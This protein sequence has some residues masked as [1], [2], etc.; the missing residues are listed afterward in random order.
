[1]SKPRQESPSFW[2][3]FGQPKTDASPPSPLWELFASEEPPPQAPVPCALGFDPG[4][5]FWAMRN[6]PITE[7]TKHFVICG[8]TG[9]G[10]TVGIQLFLQSI[11]PRFRPEAKVPEQLILFDAKCD[12]VPLL[13]ALGLGPGNSNVWILNPY[14][15]RSAVWNLGEATDTP[16]MARALAAL[17]VPDERN[18]NAPYFSDAARELVYAVLLALNRIAKTEWTLRDLLCALESREHIQEV[19]AQDPRAQ[20]LVERLLNDRH[21]SPGVLS[22]LATKVGPFEQVAALWHTNNSGRRFS[23]PD[24]LS[25]PGVLVLGN[26]PVLRESF[27]P[28]NAILL[29]ALT[30]EILR[31]PN[32][33]LPRHWFILDEFR[34]M[35]RV[36]SIHDLLNR[37]RSKG[38]AV[39][40]GLQSVEGLMEVY[41][42]NGANDILSQ[43]AQK[44]FLRVGGPKT[45]EWAENFFGKVR[46]Q[47]TSVT[48]TSGGERST[49]KHT[50][51]QER[52]MFLASFFM[53]LPFTG[54]GQPYVAVC[55]LPHLGETL[56][57]RRAF[58]E[59][60]A[61]C[62]SQEGSWLLCEEDIVN[63]AGFVRDLRR[64]D[65]AV[66]TYLWERLCQET[67]E[68]LLA[69]KGVETDT[70]SLCEALI[71]EVNDMLSEESI[72]DEEVFQ[73]VTLSPETLELLNGNP[74]GPE[75]V[76]LNRLLL[77]DA[78]PDSIAKRTTI[79]SVVARTNLE[80]QTLSPW[81]EAEEKRFCGSPKEPGA[82]PESGSRSGSKRNRRELPSRH[83]IS[84]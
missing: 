43:C 54:P 31:R 39:L 46:R 45:A 42:E 12:I 74:Q 67:R 23:I 82:S 59:V 14:D 27:W 25:R 53:D 81:S 9:S 17:L 29:K 5:V 24:F 58:D 48:E 84:H 35:E 40:L 51:L 3:L 55:D 19:A 80:D 8:A 36:E 75:L 62:H 60:I 41:G 4:H 52:S 76:R 26:D 20:R 69:F 7:A 47:E 22:T 79:P 28:I 56:I 66:S 49:A 37:G 83:K 57:V 21:H 33:R 68:A 34:A 18:S 73:A 30:N 1:M 38:A 15:A 16:V 32:T 6:L 2:S 72:Y 77:Q 10:K 64:T 63:L 71:K 65:S 50:E 78:Y 61:W 70:T 13:A 11:A 44:T